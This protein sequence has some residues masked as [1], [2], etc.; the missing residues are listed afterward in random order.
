MELAGSSLEGVDGL[1]FVP[2]LVGRGPQKRHEY[3][4][5]ESA[6]GPKGQFTQAIRWGDWK[7]MRPPNRPLELYNLS[8]D[9]SE[10]TEVAAGNP[11]IARRIEQMM[12]P[13]HE[14]PPPQI[15]PPKPAG[16]R[17]R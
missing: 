1:S 5:W 10:T 12:R 15:E 3:L 11:Q 16:Q 6:H 13:A 7:A 9:E 14:A 4:Y 8:T 17:W 2:T